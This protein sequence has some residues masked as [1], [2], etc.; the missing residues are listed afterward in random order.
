MMKTIKHP[1]GKIRSFFLKSSKDLIEKIIKF[2]VNLICKL[3]NDDKIIIS[4]ATH[5]PWKKDKDFDTFYKKVK[6]FTLLDAAR[7]YTLWQC[8]KNLK[9]KKGQILDIGCLMGGSGF[10]MSKINLEGNT[11][12]FDSFSGFRVD[13]GLHK[14]DVFVYKDMDL[15]RASWKTS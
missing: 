12:L 13:D 3:D 5:A 10:L 4:S 2:F 6:N 9:D 11:Y 15:I 7:A 1:H 8:S 14:K